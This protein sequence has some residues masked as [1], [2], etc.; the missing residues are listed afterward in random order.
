MVRATGDQETLFGRAMPPRP[1]RRRQPP[2][3]STITISADA[4]AAATVGRM[5]GECITAEAADHP[6][7]SIVT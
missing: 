3:Q 7:L 1:T 2:K 5:A 6:A 4:M